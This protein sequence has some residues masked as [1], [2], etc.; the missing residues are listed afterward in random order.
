LNRQTTCPAG[1]SPDARIAQE[2]ANTQHS[3]TCERRSGSV[4]NHGS[5]AASNVPK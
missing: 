4:D 5:I 3:I 1:L 2:T